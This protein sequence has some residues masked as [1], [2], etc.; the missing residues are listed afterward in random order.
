MLCSSS[1]KD[2]ASSLGADLCGIA[3]IDRFDGMPPMTNPAAILPGCKSVIVVA[4][5]YLQSTILSASTIP[6]TIIRNYLSSALD[7]IT[8]ELSY[9]IESEASQAVPTGA[10]EPCNWNPELS[11][12]VGLISLK[13]AG[14]KA[15]LGTIGKNTLLI[16]EKYGN[17]VWL[18][19]VLTTLELTPDPVIEAN[20]C[21]PECNRCLAQCPTGAI[22]GSNFMDQAKCWNYAF[23]EENG[24]EWRIKCNTCRTVC[25]VKGTG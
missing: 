1:I 5:R 10:I 16:T 17:M 9:F 11:K 25:P 13:N 7:R 18:G 6:Y 3:S 20:L 4:K 8:I 14:V 12:T 15:G 23:G 2:K 19:G 22:D 24:G 21:K